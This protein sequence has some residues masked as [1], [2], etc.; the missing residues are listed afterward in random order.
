MSLEKFENNRILNKIKSDLM[1]YI[2]INYTIDF[3][4]C[5]SI[6]NN[7]MTFKVYKD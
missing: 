1:D 4:Y 5:K 3:I 6:E 7:L 2:Q